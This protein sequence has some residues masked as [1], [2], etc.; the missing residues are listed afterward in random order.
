[1]QV[2]SQTES[3]PYPD[4]MFDLQYAPG[5]SYLNWGKPDLIPKDSKNK[6]LLWLTW[7]VYFFKSAPL[8]AHPS[9][10]FLQGAGKQEWPYVL[11]IIEESSAAM[12]RI[13]FDP[14]S[15][16]EGLEKRRGQGMGISLTFSKEYRSIRH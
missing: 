1:M 8:D 11:R 10:L 14:K 2:G 16:K 3:W 9:S 5:E 13:P 6:D 4:T 15:G 7:S 12:K